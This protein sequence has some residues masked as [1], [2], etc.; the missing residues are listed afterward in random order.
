MGFANIFKEIL[1][2]P[3]DFFKRVSSEKNFSDPGIFA[4]ICSL[5]PGTI[6]MREKVT[7]GALPFFFAGFLFV[8]ITRL[9]IDS[10]ILHGLFKMFGGEAVYQKSL[11]ILSYSY[12]A[13]LFVTIPILAI[14]FEIIPVDFSLVFTLYGVY[15]IT[16]GGQLI[17]NLN[18]G[19]SA[20]ASILWESWYLV[21][22]FILI[23][24]LG[25]PL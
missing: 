14:E 21:T 11:Q 22:S 12:A 1:L 4:L 20:F 5:I 10:A 6:L 2:Q 8:F 15:L 9:F 24:L 3:S 13:Y 25:I 16:R 7:W 18:F 17:H 23:T 19:K